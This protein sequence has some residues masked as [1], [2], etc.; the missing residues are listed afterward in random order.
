MWAERHLDVRI[1]L[2]SDAQRGPER[3]HVGEH[4]YRVAVAGID[5]A[6]LEDRHSVLPDKLRRP[7]PLLGGPRE[8]LSITVERPW[9][10]GLA[11]R[12]GMDRQL[13][14]EVRTLL[15]AAGL[16]ASSGRRCSA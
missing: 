7:V 13:V 10:I 6:H 12:Q 1:A 5:G 8:K 11:P 15:T 2:D 14:A 9:G 16:D 3:R 4:L